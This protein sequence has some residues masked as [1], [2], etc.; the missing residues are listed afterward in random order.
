[1]A[2]VEEAVHIEADPQ[3]VWSVLVD[4]EN[5]PR[6]MHDARS[7]V[8][9]SPHREG[10]GV[11]LRCRTNIAAGIVVNDDMTITDW[12]PD[13]VLGVR[14]LGPW[15]RGVGAFELTPTEDGTHVQWWEEVEAPLGRVGEAAATAL[16]PW[17][18]R[19]FRRSLAQ[20][21]KVSEATSATSTPA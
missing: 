7:V 11:V 3:T 21:K 15:F 13:R 6:W 19:V 9:T 4:W 5:Q 1:M 14:H 12:E 8:V 16:M 20:L 18:G 2:R 17:V 10:S